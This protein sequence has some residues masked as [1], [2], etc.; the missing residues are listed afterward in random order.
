VSRSPAPPHRQL[1]LF[2]SL[3]LL[4]SLPGGCGPSPGDPRKVESAASAPDAPSA[5]AEAEEPIVLPAAAS[6][7]PH[8]SPIRFTH[9]TDESGVDF[10]Y[11]GGPSADCEMTEQNG[12]G[13]GILDFDQDG[14]ADLFF[15]NGSTTRQPAAF[16]HTQRLY[17]GL[18]AMR[19]RDATSVSGVEG[20]GFGQGV[21]AGDLNGDGFPDLYIARYGASQL[22]LNR[23]DGTFED[24]TSTAGV[25]NDRWGTSPAFADL[26]DD[27]LLDLYVVNYVD[28]SPGSPPC[29]L[30][31]DPPVR[32]S[33]PPTMLPGQPDRLYRNRG[34]G[35]FEDIGPSAGVAVEESGKG[36]AVGIADLNGDDRLDVYVANDTTP[37]FLFVNQGNGTFVDEA[38]VQGVALSHDGT[39]GSSMGVAIGDFDGEDGQGFDIAVTN[40]LHQPNDLFQNLGPAGDRAGGG[41]LAVNSRTG[42]D[43]VSRP[44][45]KFGIAFS[46][47]DLDTR[48]D[49]LIANGH[50][51]DL[52]HLPLNY[53][54]RMPS[55]VL[56]N[57]DGTRFDDASSAA[58]EFFR[59][60][61]LARSLAVGDLDNDGDP[62]VVMGL[63]F[64]A[65]ALL[66]NDTER[67]GRSARVKLIG[68]GTARQPL[69]RRV[70]WTSGGTRLA[71][72]VPAGGSFQATHDDRL[73]L[74]T[75]GAG[76]A[77]IDEVV[78]RWGPGHSER[79][80]NLATDRLHALREGTGEPAPPASSPA[81]AL[82]PKREL[83]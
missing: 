79:W 8:P 62:D 59:K 76:A 58:G 49:L 78:V 18:G 72:P 12:G 63:L 23:G 33:C 32:I 30:P 41:F 28:W 19:Y 14:V 34:D 67:V 43:I 70:E 10:R 53:A 35:T 4:F 64:D 40:F 56:R 17:R 74:T 46:D 37:N 11:Y 57:R 13:I 60:S 24:A 68:T 73:L 21:A 75:S 39:A 36:L 27:G 26:D 71:M 80:T 50:I 44:F 16:P 45:L 2:L 65:P 15:S 51:W 20:Y 52:S 29:S 55:Q 77:S 48:P 83:R 5:E 42:L 31:Y 25:A 3:S 22:L 81:S 61:W 1:R 54:Y 9:V 69:G 6:A 66:R 47:L 82:R 7:L 38:V